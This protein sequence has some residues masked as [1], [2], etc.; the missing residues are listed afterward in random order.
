V[1][2]LL[3]RTETLAAS[4]AVVAL[5][6][7]TLRAMLQNK[8]KLTV[9]TLLFLGLIAGGAGLLGRSSAMTKD[10]P[11]PLPT[12][13]QPGPASKLGR[14]TPSSNADRIIISGRVLGPDGKSVDGAQVAV[15]AMPQPQPQT[16]DRR[17]PDRP[18]VL[19]SARADALGRFRVDFPRITPDRD[20]FGLVAWATGWALAGQDI[21]PN[22]TTPDETITLEP[23]RIFRGRLID[24]QVQPIPGVSVR[25][26][27]YQIGPYETAGELPH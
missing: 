12:G 21:E 18:Q 15:V 26:I 8:L 6:R 3:S 7:G 17:E 23:E 2:V 9:L 24:L 25:V 27:W 5:A 11:K 14:A 13:V 20:G 10:E 4:G 1:G 22:L 19:G 16:R